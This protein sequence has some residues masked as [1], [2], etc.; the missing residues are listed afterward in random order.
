MLDMKRVVVVC[1]ARNIIAPVPA[2][3]LLSDVNPPLPRVN[4]GYRPTPTRAVS[5]TISHI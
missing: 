3:D 1:Y 5:H 4:M 2:D